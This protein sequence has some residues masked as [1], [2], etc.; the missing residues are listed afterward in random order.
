MVRT[1]ASVYL[2]LVVPRLL[3]GA[4]EPGTSRVLELPQIYDFVWDATRS[5]LFVSAG[6]SIL[7]VDPETGSIEETIAS[8]LIAT[9]IAVSDDGQYLYAG[10][11]ARGVIHRFE[12]RTRS[13]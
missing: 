10:I 4:S 9:R 8:G 6:S 1:L 12:L 7:M 5:R 2:L 13:Q 11:G 3:P